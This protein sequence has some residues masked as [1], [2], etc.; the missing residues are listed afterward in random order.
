MNQQEHAHEARELTARARQEQTSGGNN[1]IAAEF[2]WGAFA[3]CLI[4]VALNEGL[5]HDSHGA[6]RAIT[7]H[8][9]AAQGGNQWR[10]HFGSAG[11]LHRHFYHGHLT[12]RLLQSY[13][14]DTA[15]GTAQMLTML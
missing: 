7:Q 2:L 11:R 8:M 10:S 3:H 9:D 13:S 15:N 6:F 12:N 4:A 14:E 1:R 5:P